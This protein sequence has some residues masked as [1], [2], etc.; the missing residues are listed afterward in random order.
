MAVKY[1]EVDIL[2]EGIQ[3]AEPT[4]GN[5]AL[6]MLRRQGAWERRGQWGKGGRRGDDSPACSPRPAP[7]ISTGTAA[8][9]S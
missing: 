9:R 3:Y 2:D 5:F 4:K 8:L 1:E 6:N 7:P